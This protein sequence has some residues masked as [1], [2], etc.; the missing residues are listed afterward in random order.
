LEENDRDNTGRAKERDGRYDCR[1]QEL[2][3]ACSAYLRTRIRIRVLDTDYTSIRGGIID[4][5]KTARSVPAQSIN[6]VMIAT[7]WEIGCRIFESEMRGEKRTDYGE[8]LVER[9]AIDLTE[10]F[11]RGF[12]EISLWRIRAF[13]Q[14]WPEKQILS[15]LLKESGVSASISTVV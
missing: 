3:F 12:G 10:Q 7:Y 13:F 6:A 14:A 2:V 15:I 11:G 4:L 5:L 1:S 9:L 8:R